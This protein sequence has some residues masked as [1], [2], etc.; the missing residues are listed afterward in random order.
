MDRKEIPHQLERVNPMY[1]KETLAPLNQRFINSHYWLTDFDADLANKLVELIEQS[2]DP[3]RPMPGDIVEYTTVHGDFYPN[4]HIER[5]YETGLYIC[6]Q[7]Y[8]PFVSDID[9]KLSFS[10]SGGAWC[11]IPRNLQRIGTRPKLFTEFGHTGPCANGAI[12]FY[13]EVNV[14]TYTQKNPY[15]P[16]T[17]RDWRR[18]YMH[19]DEKSH[20]PFGYHYYLDGTAFRTE[21]EYLAWLTTYHGVEFEGFWPNQ[22]V[23]FCYRQN[24]ILLPREEWDKLALPTDTRLMNGTIIDIKYQVN[25]ETH[26]ITEYRYENAAEDGWNFRYRRPYEAASVRVERGEIHR[27]IRKKCREQE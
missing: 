19:Y 25:D 14:W 4:A 7:P 10:T 1:T 18:Y 17:T 11:E 13:A 2:R 24:K 22:T 8:V 6:E 5:E 21:K 23:I 27:E 15:F 26:V 9:G 16:Y 3:E 12:E 20:D